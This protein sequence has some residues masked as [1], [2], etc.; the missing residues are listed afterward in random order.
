VRGEKPRNPEQGLGFDDEPIC[1]RAWENPTERQATSMTIGTR[2]NQ[3]NKIRSG[4]LSPVSALGL[5]EGKIL[6]RINRMQLKNKIRQDQKGV[7][8]NT[9]LA[10]AETPQEQAQPKSKLH[11]QK[12]R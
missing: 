4:Q 2:T 5:T 6:G 8:E 9:S 11:R 10:A 7:G 1:T 3:R 12:F